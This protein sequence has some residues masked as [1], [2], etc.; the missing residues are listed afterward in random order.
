M[1][2][3]QIYL[4]S[5]SP[6]RQQILRD[7][8]FDFQLWK[9]DVNEQF[10]PEMPAE[11][12]PSYL[13]AKKMYAAARQLHDK[14][15]VIITADTVVI[16][17]G[18][19]IGKPEDEADACN[20]LSR[21]AGQTHTVITAVCLRKGASEQIITSE[22][23]VFMLPMSMEEIRHYVVTARPLDKA[24]AYAIQEW[25][26]LARISRIEGDYYNV[27]GFPMSAV[28]PH[29]KALLEESD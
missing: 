23:K 9:M 1:N 22:T 5:G 8:G 16:L 10:P 19:I 4:A 28:Y 29:L 24:G 11:D 26:G 7:A 13:A 6:R 2:K 3:V 18:R 12:V 25:V 21:L 14:D 20:I 17:N 27:V 15:G